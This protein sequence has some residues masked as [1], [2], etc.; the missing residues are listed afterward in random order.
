M[1]HLLQQQRVKSLQQLVPLQLQPPYFVFQ[2]I[3][4]R[5]CS[6][7]HSSLGIPL[8]RRLFGGGG[9]GCDVDARALCGGGSSTLAFA[10]FERESGSVVF[11]ALGFDFAGAGAGAFAL[12]CGWGGGLKHARKNDDALKMGVWKEG[13]GGAPDACARRS[14]WRI[15]DSAASTPDASSPSSSNAHNSNAAESAADGNGRAHM[16]GVMPRAAS[17]L[18][19]RGGEMRRVY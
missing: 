8:L 3:F 2:L 9:G 10:Q 6:R 17:S 7:S 14:S 13:R 4:P 19:R 5:F 11:E 15:A 12:G 16:Q 18:R 1:S